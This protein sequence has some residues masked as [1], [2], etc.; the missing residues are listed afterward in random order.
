MRS[1][2][3]RRRGA[4]TL[5]EVMLVL[6]IMVMLGSLAVGMFSKAQ[7]KAQIDTAQSQIGA[8]DSALNMYM[9]AMNDFPSTGSGLEALVSRP[10][11]ARNTSRWDGPYLDRVVPADPWDNPFQYSYPGSRNPDKYDLWSFGPDGQDGTDDD[12]GNW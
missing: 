8:F 2:A 6:V 3:R 4:F 1:N 11:D 10:T 12:I 5:M 7:R 9:L